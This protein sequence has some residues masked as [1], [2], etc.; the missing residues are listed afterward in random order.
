LV[1]HCD[2]TGCDFVERAGEQTPGACG[3]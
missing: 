1:E 2:L 3:R